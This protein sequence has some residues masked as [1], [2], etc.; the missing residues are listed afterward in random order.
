MSANEKETLPGLEQ[1]KERY[2]SIEPPPAL[3]YAVRSAVASAKGA[4]RTPWWKPVIYTAA[5]CC[6]LFVA[7]LNSSRVFAESI[8]TLPVLGEVARVFTFREYE[9]ATDENVI[10]VKLPAIANTGNDELEQ[11]VNHTILTKMNEI[12]QEAKTRAKAY[13]EA[14][15][16]TGG[17]PEDFL[18]VQLNVDYQVHHSDERLLSFVITKSE[19]F[20]SAYTEQYYYNFDLQSGRE[21]TLYD[22]LGDG[23][24]QR[25]SDSIQRQIAQR[26]AENPDN[27]YF[28]EVHPFTAITADQTFYINEAGNVVVTFAKYSIAPGYM[29]I[30]EF[31]L[32]M[33]EGDR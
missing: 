1:A 7:L 30:Q 20:A 28:K 18:P 17:N 6:V 8:R 31:E 12:V 21:L 4:R 3:S 19:S 24:I 25:V 5:T 29:G 13:Q 10:K 14:F 26:E 33:P 23:Y 2:Q 32:E 16:A 15:V 11:R 9:E 27:L 22:L